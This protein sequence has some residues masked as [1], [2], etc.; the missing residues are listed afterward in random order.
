MVLNFAKSKFNF[1]IKKKPVEFESLTPL[2]S[3]GP[4][5]LGYR[6]YPWGFS[7]DLERVWKRLL[8]PPKL[9]RN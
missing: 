1:I 3:P 7:S 2:N 4:T 8:I 6:F 9:V 5:F